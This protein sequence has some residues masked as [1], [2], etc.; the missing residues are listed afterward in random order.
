[1][2][3]VLMPKRDGKEQKGKEQK[4]KEAKEAEYK[5]QQRR[6]WRRTFKMAHIIFSA[7][8]IID[9]FNQQFKFLFFE[10]DF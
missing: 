8:K 9:K 5:Q 3:G 6:K 2:G 7:W 10:T 1:M 4:G